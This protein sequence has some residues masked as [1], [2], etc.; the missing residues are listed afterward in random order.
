MKL[1]KLLCR[2]AAKGASRGWAAAKSRRGA[3]PR[4][5]LHSVALNRMGLLT[6]KLSA[7]VWP[8][9]YKVLCNRYERL[10]LQAIRRKALEK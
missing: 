4:E 7:H 10:S 8:A 2:N 1:C 3:V 9:E 6:P 5:G